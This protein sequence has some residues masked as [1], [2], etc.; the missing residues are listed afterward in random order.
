[1]EFKKYQH[2]ARLGTSE[3][4]GIL[5]GKV[6][7]QPKID[8]TNASVYLNDDGTLGCGSRKRALTLF[9]DNQ[10]F[11]GHFHKK[12]NLINYFK[13]HPNHRLY[14]EFLKPH[15]LKTYEDEAWDKFYVFDVCVDNDEETEYLKYDDYQPL[16]DEFEIDYIPVISTMTNPTMEQILEVLNS[17][18][19]LIKEDSGCGEGIVIKNYDYTNKYGKRTWAK[20]IRSEY[21]NK[22]NKKSKAQLS[23][24]DIAIE[25]KISNK[26][27]TEALVEKEYQKIINGDNFD[28][29]TDKKR[30]IPCLIN[31]IY[32]SIIN[33]EMWNVVKDY[34]KP[35]INFKT[36]QSEI[37][38]RI[39]QI[40]PD[41]FV[42]VE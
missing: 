39:K 15:S 28:P 3:T 23:M 32:Y 2:V 14:G 9:K 20:V 27:V 10:G 24:D 12:E 4:E 6:Y 1:M 19:Y 40:K 38:N 37:V 35:T 25:N 17:N 16:L 22:A 5:N 33:E 41:L 13:K 21:F 29:I 18:N 26:Y 42:R 8:G 7:I 34:K 31:I 36:L 30:L 11:Y